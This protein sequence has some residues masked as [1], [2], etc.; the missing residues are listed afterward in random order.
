MEY[1]EILKLKEML[2]KA[3]IPFVFTDDLFGTKT[4]PIEL[5][6][7]I[8][9]LIDDQ[10]PAYAIKILKNDKLLCDA[11]EH[12]GSYGNNQDL[13]EICGALTTEEQENDTVLG[14]LTAEEVFKRFKYC[15]ENN[16]NI[17]KEV[18]KNGN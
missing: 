18:N 9:D 7:Q 1:K 16:T 2:E 12:T 8:Q 11:I 6:Q 13:I 5:R 4:I 17:Y 10:Y 3:N 15:Y 14:Y